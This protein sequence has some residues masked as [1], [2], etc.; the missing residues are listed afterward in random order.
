MQARGFKKQN[1]VTMKFEV[2]NIMRRTGMRGFMSRWSFAEVDGHNF[3][4]NGNKPV[5][6]TG[7]NQRFL[8]PEITTGNSLFVPTELAA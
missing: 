4:I 7:L 2:P 6:L 5:V 3:S 8:I 1:W